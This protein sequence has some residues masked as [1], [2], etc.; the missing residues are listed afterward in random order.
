ME[1][2]IHGRLCLCYGRARICFEGVEHYAVT[3]AQK[4]ENDNA[5]A[6]KP[7]P[8]LPSPVKDLHNGKLHVATRKH[9]KIVKDYNNLCVVVVVVAVVCCK[10]IHFWSF[11]SSIWGVGQSSRKRLKRVQTG[12]CVC[13]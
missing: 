6:N 7:H 8:L 11:T 9:N 13:V 1:A 5:I 2:I 10:R 12:E 4:D 3:V